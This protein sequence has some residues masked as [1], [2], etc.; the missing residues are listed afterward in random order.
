MQSKHP[1]DRLDTSERCQRHD[2]LDRRLTL[3][4]NGVKTIIPE[5]SNDP[6]WMSAA[7]QGHMHTVR[8][9]F[10]QMPLPAILRR[11]ETMLIARLQEPQAFEC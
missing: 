4:G 9:R 7:K 8:Q 10:Q 3:Y 11:H 6:G 5:R 2:V 1:L